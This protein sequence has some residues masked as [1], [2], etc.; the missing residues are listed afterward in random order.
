MCLHLFEQSWTQAPLKDVRCRV[1]WSDTCEGRCGWRGGE[2]GGGG[3]GAVTTVTVSLTDL[4]PPPPFP[5]PQHRGVYQ[6]CSTV[7]PYI[8][9]HFVLFCPDELRMIFMIYRR[10]V[11]ST[12][13]VWLYLCLSILEELSYISLALLVAVVIINPTRR[14]EGRC[15]G[16]A[17]CFSIE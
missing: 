15:Q 14:W 12:L 8:Y 10:F 17:L 11:L 3:G 4:S 16:I 2:G 5:L 1:M 6:G 7:Y 13:S 9:L